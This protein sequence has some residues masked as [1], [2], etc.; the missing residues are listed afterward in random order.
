MFATAQAAYQLLEDLNIAYQRVDHEPIT[1]VKNVPFTLPGPQVKNLVLQPRKGEHRFLV[2]LPDE[3][4]ADLTHLAE[5]LNEK[6]L[7]FVS[8]KNL[9][10][11][12]N[13]P[14]GSV[15][16]LALPNDHDHKITVVID[17]E[18]DQ[19]DTVGFHP[20]INSTTLIMQFRD[21]EKILNHLGYKPLYVA[22]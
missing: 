3:K 10:E 13:V 22:I 14:A 5:I 16:P 8:E 17:K 1:S 9:V 21:F 4:Q 6:R 15:T 19:Q 12:L 7:S 2:I 18:I 11:L 20:N